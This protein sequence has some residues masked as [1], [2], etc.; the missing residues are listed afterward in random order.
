VE[1]ILLSAGDKITF[2]LLGGSLELA[3]YTPDWFIRANERGNANLKLVL[4]A[5]NLPEYSLIVSPTVAGYA[6]LK[7]KRIGVSAVKSSDAYFIKRMMAA[8]GI[9]AGGYTLIPA[10]QSNERAS[11]LRAGSIA[12]TL[13]FPPLDQ[14]FV[15]EEKF[16]R[17]DVTSSVIKNY[18]WKNF[19]V[20]DD[21]A[22]ANRGLLVSFIRCWV[23]GARWMFDPA[24]AA[25]ATKGIAKEVKLSEQYAQTAYKDSYS[26]ERPSVRRDGQL[27][28]V[29]IQV[30][31]DGIVEQG[32]LPASSSLRAARF[33]DDSYWKEA[34]APK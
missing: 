15:D 3:A 2:A 26:G 19:A 11:A 18:A 4:Q 13:L 27:D 28:P 24:N 17:L 10:G 7:G 9:A 25:A 21:W 23:N 1:Q 5:S 34:V 32:D 29:G 6:D 22:K 8:N 33:V 16:K 14:R 20:R 12:G 30:V 31:I